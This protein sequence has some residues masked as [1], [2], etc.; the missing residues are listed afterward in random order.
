MCNIVC[1]ITDEVSLPYMDKAEVYKEFMADQPPDSDISD[2]WFYQIWLKE[3]PHVKI[4][5][6]K[7]MGTCKACEK[8]HAM[9]LD[10]KT[11]DE[12]ETIKALRRSHMDEVRAERRAYHKKKQKAEQDPNSFMLL[13]IDAMDQKKTDIPKMA[14]TLAGDDTIKVLRTAV[15]GVK[16]KGKGAGNYIYLSHPDI[17]HG[18]NFMLMGLVDTLL[19][20]GLENLPDVIFLQ[21][22]NTVKDNKNYTVLAFEA[23]YIECLTGKTVITGFLPVGHTHEDID[24]LFSVIARHLKGKPIG[25]MESLTEAIENCM[26]PA[27]KVFVWKECIDFASFIRP[28]LVSGN[29]QIKDLT[30]AHEFLL[31]RTPFASKALFRYK[32]WCRHEDWLPPEGF[33]VI[34]GLP[35]TKPNYVVRRFVDY[36]AILKS[37][38][39]V[40]GRMR[41]THYNSFVKYVTDLDELQELRCSTCKRWRNQEQQNGPSKKDPPIRV[42]EKRTLRTAAQKAMA[43]HLEEKEC[44]ELKQVTDWPFKLAGDEAEE[45][46][47]EYLA[48]VLLLEQK[49][50]E[51]DFSI[52]F[53]ALDDDNITPAVYVGTKPKKTVTRAPAVGDLIIL[54]ASDDQAFWVAMVH[55]INGRS[56]TVRW[57]GLLD[58]KLPRRYEALNDAD[59]GEAWISQPMPRDTS[60]LDWGFALNRT[61]RIKRSVLK[62]IHHDVRIEWTYGEQE[63]KGY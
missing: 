55:E 28:K 43:A 60:I 17:P 30:N 19:H 2:S 8:Y 62:N 41:I 49:E 45:E 10:A 36:K 21:V 13:T 47:K 5:A 18:A 29:R 54:I 12:R 22:D 61:K 25:S 20:I 34:T 1:Y 11:K 3:F 40:K 9:L 4:S 7:K 53:E 23:Y 37:V 15:L 35:D 26:T 58:K 51:P 6:Y 33:E 48:P 16:V 14:R 52:L 24:Q 50:D 59:T 38:E 63:Q 42:A 32:M 46:E 39:D 57:Y 31:T 27:P 44:D 56:F